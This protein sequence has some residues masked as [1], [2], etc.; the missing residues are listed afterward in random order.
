MYELWQKHG[1]PMFQL[2]KQ[3]KG[4]REREL[5]SGWKAGRGKGREM[6]PVKEEGVALLG[7][8]SQ[9]LLGAL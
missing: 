6:P 2:T 8:D 1:Q 7:L 5:Q 9:A 4:K 3:S